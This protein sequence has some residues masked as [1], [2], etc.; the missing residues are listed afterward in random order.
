V[1]SLGRRVQARLVSLERI[2]MQARALAPVPAG[3]RD[4]VERGLRETLAR[5]VAPAGASAQLRVTVSAAMAH[6]VLV[7]EFVRGEESAI[8]MAE[9]E[10]SDAASRPMRARPVLERTLLWEQ[11]ERILDAAVVPGQGDFW[12]LDTGGLT[13]RNRQGEAIRETRLRR[14][15]DP[16][17]RDV[18]G[19]L[20][21]V[22]GGEPRAWLP[23]SGAGAWPVASGFEA[24]P[25]GENEFSAGGGGRFFTA[26]RI[27]GSAVVLAGVDGRM[28]WSEA[29]AAAR[30]IDGLWG[31]EVAALANPCGG[32]AVVI[33]SS[34]DGQSLGVYEPAP[35]ALRAA[36]EV[37]TL[38]GTLSALWPAEGDT[39]ATA[40]VRTAAGRYAAYR[41]SAGCNR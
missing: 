17:P 4:R 21:M 23:G 28:R 18:R 31:T 39:S 40:V 9:Y 41:V 30:E 11:D 12:V 24:M 10:T 13:L 14:N 8:M 25:S 19:R 15:G 20:Q 35:R 37:M 32:G 1:R 34:R 5:N 16:W 2:S 27:S 7:A 26:A 36:G 38:P 29:G 33:A 22:A 3:E 6:R